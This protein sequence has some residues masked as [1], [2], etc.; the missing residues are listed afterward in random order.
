[1][2][3]VP[4]YAQKLVQS[5]A[6]AIESDG[7]VNPASALDNI[8]ALSTADIE[9]YFLCLLTGKKLTDQERPAL[10]S[11]LREQIAKK[12][13]TTTDHLPICVKVGGHF[14]LYVSLDNSVRA[15]QNFSALKNGRLANI[16]E[17]VRNAIA[18]CGD[19]CV[20][21][22]SESCRPSFD[23]ADLSNRLD[24]RSWFQMRA[25]IEELTSLYY[26]SECSNN[27]D[28]SGMAFGVSAF[29]TVSMK[30]SIHSV[31][32]RHI[33][34]E[35]FGSG[36]VGVKLITSEIVWGIH[37]P[38]DFKNK[39]SDNLGAKTM[40]NLCNLMDSHVGS[41]CA[42]GD[43]NLIPGPIT[44]SINQAISPNKK[45]IVKAD[46]LSFFG[47]YPDKIVPRDGEEWILL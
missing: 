41:I 6:L 12:E 7:K 36:C 2:Q 32:P 30:G 46:E 16:C 3:N 10:Y 29:C 47:S 45:F 39:G 13:Y 24:E 15:N 35:G 33:L 26:L 23:G 18:E 27:E 19:K 17:L 31:L 11:K 34:S 44:E 20:V 5:Y 42:I 22:F 43:Y 28:P 4:T 21:F 40:V 9:Y 1:M 14:F 37:F 8:L 25:Q 38:L